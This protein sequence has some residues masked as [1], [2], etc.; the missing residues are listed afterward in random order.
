MAYEQLQEIINTKAYRIMVSLLGVRL[1][2]F[3]LGEKDLIRKATDR[4][5]GRIPEII[6]TNVYRIMVSLLG[7]RLLVFDLGELVDYE[8]DGR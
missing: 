8:N 5:A 7:V 6:N 1:L 4:A 3:D 2:V